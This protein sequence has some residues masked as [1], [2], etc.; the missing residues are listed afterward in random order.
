M[1]QLYSKYPGCSF[2]LQ[3]V[4]FLIIGKE[5]IVDGKP[6]LTLGLMW[7]LIQHYSSFGDERSSASTEVKP[8]K[9]GALKEKLLAWVNDKIPSLTVNNFTSNWNDGRAIGALVDALSPGMLNNF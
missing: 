8:G 4:R 7:E 3:H 9:K 5:D 2:N 6:K 1:P